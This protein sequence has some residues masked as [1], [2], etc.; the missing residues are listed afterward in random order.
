MQILPSVLLLLSC[1]SGRV[2]RL[3]IPKDFVLLCRFSGLHMLMESINHAHVA[4]AA[5]P[6]SDGAAVREEQCAATEE[7]GAPSPR[8]EQAPLLAGEAAPLHAEAPSPPAVAEA[9]N[10]MDIKPTDD[11]DA[12]KYFDVPLPPETDVQ[13]LRK[14]KNMAKV[15]KIVGAVRFLC[16]DM[17]Q[18]VLQLFYVA[19]NWD[20]VSRFQ[21]AQIIGS[22]GVGLTVSAIGPF[23]ESQ[24]FA[25]SSTELI[26]HD[27][28]VA[29]GGPISKHAEDIIAKEKKKRDGAAFDGIGELVFDR[30]M[31]LLGTGGAEPI[32]LRNG[33]VARPNQV[34]TG[35]G[36]CGPQSKYPMAIT[37][38][39]LGFTNVDGEASNMVPLYN[40]C[41]GHHP[42]VETVKFSAT[43]P[44]R[45]G[46][47]PVGFHKDMQ[48]TMEDAKW[49]FKTV[50]EDKV[51]GYV[52]VAD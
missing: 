11:S 27:K 21:R 13:E 19:A 52:V 32:I 34:V 20:D 50:S 3:G 22:V 5:E 38:Y 18:G 51:I 8:A 45:P 1:L 15:K 16:E 48:Y 12:S 44:P 28:W 7:V 26:Q 30:S 42:K 25:K 9:S 49:R 33:T 40:D 23:M 39:I 36:T 37:Q 35:C 29:A 6:A 41:P 17:L 10:S 24:K 43:A 14:M 46:I 31:R 4:A 47:Y 2:A